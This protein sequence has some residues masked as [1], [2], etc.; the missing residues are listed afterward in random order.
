[1]T[2]PGRELAAGL[3][4]QNLSVVRNPFSYPYQAYTVGGYV[5]V[6]GSGLDSAAPAQPKSPS[7]TYINAT[8]GVIEGWVDADPTFGVLTWAAVN[9]TDIWILGWTGGTG[10]PFTNLL[11]FDTITKVLT[12][13]ATFGRAP[14]GIAIHS[15]NIYIA[16]VNLDGGLIRVAI[17]A[18]TIVLDFMST[19]SY[20]VF[21]AEAIFGLMIDPSTT[22]Y[23]DGL[24]RVW[25]FRIG[26]SF[27][28]SLLERFPLTGFTGPDGVSINF[29]GV[30]SMV[31]YGATQLL[32]CDSGS[33]SIVNAS[34][35]T[36]AAS[37]SIPF[38][39]TGHIMPDG[40]GE[41]IVIGTQLVGTDPGRHQLK[42]ARMN[43]TGTVSSSAVRDDSNGND[44]TAYNHPRVGAI[45]AG[46]Y[47]ACAPT[48]IAGMAMP[49]N[50]GNVYTTPVAG[51]LSLTVV[52]DIAPPEVLWR[53]P[54]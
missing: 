24:G 19:S 38:D 48:E 12:L 51:T 50:T 23:G 29:I 45:A 40:S 2:F 44:A 47:F 4:G 8:T 35:Q 5:Y 18:P 31:T 27:I 33:L 1:M 30:R 42:V 25:W 17:A 9:G 41:Y 32:T 21:G 43:G 14:Q 13:E 39:E 37:N 28:P 11:K 26:L 34:A 15:G 36:V 53:T 6:I 20:D 46:K 16:G 52:P 3:L 54:P 49:G 22:T 10:S 7:I